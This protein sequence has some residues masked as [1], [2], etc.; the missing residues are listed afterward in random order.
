MTV[1]DTFVAAYDWY[2]TLFVV[3][4]RTY[5]SRSFYVICAI[6]TILVILSGIGGI[7]LETERECRAWCSRLALGTQPHSYMGFILFLLMAFRTKESYKMYAA[8]QRAHFR[9]KLALR[10]FVDAMLNQTARDA[11]LPEH[12]ARLLAFSVVFPYTLTADLRHER[13]YG[14]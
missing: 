2:K 7:G 14:M 3:D 1:I 13:K 5:V 11:I 9:I 4:G 8:G 6:G 12:R 10:R